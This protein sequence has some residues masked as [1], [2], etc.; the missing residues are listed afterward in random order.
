MGGA[1]DAKHLV[2][3]GIKDDNIDW[4]E[5]YV[6][7]IQYALIVQYQNQDKSSNHTFEMDTAGDANES[8]YQ[9]S[10][11]TVANVTA[12]ADLSTASY[13][14]GDIANCV[15][16]DDATVESTVAKA[17]S[18]SINSAFVNVHCGAVA[19]LSNDTSGYTLDSLNTL[20]S[21]TLDDNLA[22]TA[23]GAVSA[24]IESAEV[25]GTAN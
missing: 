23:I 21:V 1:V 5:G 7:N 10:N 25:D 2:L 20:T 13:G 9:E 19:T 8:A 17:N 16:I 11:P 14:V 18:N 24:T 15:Y 22:E 3:T 4:D 12:I 6:G